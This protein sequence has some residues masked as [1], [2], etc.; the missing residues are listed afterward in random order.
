MRK[1][2]SF[3]NTQQIFLIPVT[4]QLWWNNIDNA[5]AKKEMF[6]ELSKFLSS[7]PGSTVRQALKFLYQPNNIVCDANHFE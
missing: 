2:V 6:E 5:R 3:S 7:H 4:P 1:S